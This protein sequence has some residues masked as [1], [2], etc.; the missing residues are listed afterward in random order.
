[1]ARQIIN[2]G[3]SPNKG[4]GDP[5]RIAF[6]KI[7]SNFEELYSA[8]TAGSTFVGDVLGSVFSDD[9]TIIIDGT[10]GSIP[11]YISKQ[12]LK[13]I[14]AVSTDFDDFKNRVSNL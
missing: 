4:D 3:S 1:M 6:D 11:G 14:V 8:S 5:L 13:D 2:L 10:D 9:S 12:E 7:N